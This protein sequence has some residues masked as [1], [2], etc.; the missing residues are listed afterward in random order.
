MARVGYLVAPGEDA[1][2]SFVV[3]CAFLAALPADT[4]PPVLAALD[5]L[6]G[7]PTVEAES[8]VA[9]LP[10]GGDR[11]V[12]SF[13]VIVQREP[14]DEDGVPVS[15]IVRGEIAVDV[16]SVGGS[17]RFAAGDIRPWLLAD[18]RAVTGL[19][20]GGPARPVVPAGLLDSGRPFLGGTVSAS[21]LFWTLVD[22]PESMEATIIRAPR[23][24]AVDADTVLR[25]PRAQEDTVI[26]PA[27]GSRGRGRAP[28]PAGPPVAPDH[29]FYGFRLPD[30][31]EVRLDVACRL[32]RRP[33]PA[34]VAEVPPPRLFEVVS[35]T[36]A[37]SATHLDIRQVGDS[38][39]VT[40]L[41]STNGT[42]VTLPR[43]HP[44]RL[45]SRQ[46][47]AVLPGTRLDIGDGNIIEILPASGD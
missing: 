8:L 6:T 23:P 30:T 39:V 13:A 24:A 41:G 20:I 46:S 47:L 22:Q 29:A 31:T 9:L 43:R 16:F 12:D 5:A 2:W 27:R 18:F 17:R 28:V 42:I 26:L 36:S 32:G 7:A 34:R 15:V 11:A 21:R 37:V 3:G 35:P 40:D 38:V 14:T 19:V 25:V 33:R 44:Q 10:L 45:G 4:P 1:E